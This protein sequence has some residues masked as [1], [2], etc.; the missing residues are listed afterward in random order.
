MNY[1]DSLCNV[2]L[3]FEIRPL[4]FNIMVGYMTYYGFF[5]QI[6][7]TNPVPGILKKIMPDLL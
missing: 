6:M 1:I 5:I 7:Q 2:A 4:R 3:L